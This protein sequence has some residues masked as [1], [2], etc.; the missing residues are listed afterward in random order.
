M[1][2]RLTLL[3]LLL[4]TLAFGWGGAEHLQITAEAV[5]VMTGELPARPVNTAPS[6]P[7]SFNWQRGIP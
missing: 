5:R 4:P 1:S 3:H 7:S 6:V 2:Y